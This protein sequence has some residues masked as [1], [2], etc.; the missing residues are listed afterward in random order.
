MTDRSSDTLRSSL[1]IQVPGAHPRPTASKSPRGGAQELVFYERHVRA[2]CC[3]SWEALDETWHVARS[4]SLGLTP[5]PTTSRFCTWGKALPRSE[6]QYLHLQNEGLS[7]CLPSQ[8]L[9]GA[10]QDSR[11]RVMDVHS[12]SRAGCGGGNGAQGLGH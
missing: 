2:L 9:R 11:P 5:R 3:S 7:G 12:P 1:Q 4:A 10:T 8:S 6:P